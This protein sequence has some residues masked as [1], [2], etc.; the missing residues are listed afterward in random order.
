M[1]AEKRSVAQSDGSEGSDGEN[2]RMNE[3]P[4]GA[5]MN[6]V[7]WKVAIIFQ[8]SRIS[9]VVRITKSRMDVIDQHNIFSTAEE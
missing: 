4:K 2:K 7:S 1:E 6:D 3:G 5:S 9:K 8:I